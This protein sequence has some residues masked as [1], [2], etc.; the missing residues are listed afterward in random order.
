MS[1]TSPSK[2]TNAETIDSS[3]IRILVLDNI[4]QEGLDLLEKADGIEYEIQTGLAGEELQSALAQFDG[5]VCRSGVKIT[6]DSL[7]G[8]TRLKAI[9]RAGVGTD[10]IDKAAA[11]RLGIVVMNTPTGNTV[12][13][14]EHTMALMLGLSRNLAPAHASLLAGKWDRKKFSGRQLAGKTLGIVGLGRIGQEVASRAKSFGMNIIGYDPFLS[15]SQ[16]EQLGIEPCT[17]VASLLPVI[18]YLTVHTPLT[19]E[20]EGLIGSD[21]IAQIK[22]GA[23][24]INCA[25]GGIYDEQALAEGLKSGKL[26][27]VAL[28]VYKS[29]PCTDSPLFEM[30]GVLC[31]PHLGASTEEAQIQVAE[32]AVTLLTKYLKHGE[33]RHAVNTIAVDPQTM[34]KIRGY[35]DVAYRLGIMMCGWHGGAIESVSLEYHGELVDQDTRLLTSAFCVGVL[36]NIADNANII[37]AATLCEER[38]LDVVTRASRENDTFSSM[39][40]VTVRSSS[41][42]CQASGTLFG[43]DMPRL[44]MVDNYPTDAFMDGYLLIF[45]HQDI[46]GVIGYVGNVLAKEKVNI[47]QMAVGRMSVDVGGPAIGVLNL[48]SPAPQSALDQVLEYEGIDTVRMISLPAHDQL[49]DWLS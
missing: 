26:G 38:G 39:I 43:K 9:A 4:A 35:L 49:P 28:D 33:I 7:M 31:T 20:T 45:T 13:T 47:A 3:A 17:T 41:L 27:G 8:N 22:P 5:A 19:P 15:N 24:L 12:S 18:D 21:Q 1:T 48:D 36:E 32:E 25:R 46:P 6:A 34:E 14:A 29:E 42:E 10:N 2:P 30:A 44:V 23:R 11:T 37:N 16:I 40:S